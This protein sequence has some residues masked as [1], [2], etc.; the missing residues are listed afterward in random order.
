MR[1]KKVISYPEAQDILEND[2]VD[3]A[4]LQSGS[5]TPNP[6]P[7]GLG[8]YTYVY[9]HSDYCHVMASEAAAVIIRKSFPR[10]SEIS[11]LGKFPCFL[12]DDL[13][14]DQ[15]AEMLAELDQVPTT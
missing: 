5:D 7:D 12:A 6:Q 8:G 1:I 11:P 9:E 10:W 4:V 3:V 13:M 15:V 14:Y 2:R